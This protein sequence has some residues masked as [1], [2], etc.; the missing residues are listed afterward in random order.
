MSTTD[1]SSADRPNVM[2]VKVEL[3]K[4]FLLDRIRERVLARVDDELPAA[5][6]EA[7]ERVSELVGAGAPERL[8]LEGY[9]TRV[10]E[11][12]M[13]EPARRP[14]PWLAERVQAAGADGV[15]GTA[16]ALAREEP[17]EKPRPGPNAAPSWRIPGPGGHV[18]HFLAVM[19]AAA[20]RAEAGEDVDELALK[21]VWMFGFYVRCCEEALGA[22]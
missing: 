17:A 3:V 19:S 12:E 10:V 15:A 5:A 14:I 18:R 22:R 6:R 11:V 1:G 2:A 20:L 21:C 16:A 4:E 9:L 8:A 7:L 13:F